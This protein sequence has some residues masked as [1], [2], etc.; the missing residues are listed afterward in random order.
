MIVLDVRHYCANLLHP[1][2]R[3]LRSCSKE[4]R[5]K[6]HQYIREQMKSISDSSTI[7]TIQQE[8]EPASK[9]LKLADDLFSQFE[10]DN[11]PHTLKIVFCHLQ[12][13]ST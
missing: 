10:D 11:H 9:K 4:E 5:L 2:Y 12:Y 13:K 6:C 7:A 8:V 3:S 1:K